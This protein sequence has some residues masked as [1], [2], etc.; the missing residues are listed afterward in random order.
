MAR[1]VYATTPSR[2]TPPGDCDPVTH[3]KLQ[4]EIESKCKSNGTQRCLGTDARATVLAKLDVNRA[5]ALARTKLMN[6]C[7][8]GGD[9]GHQDAARNAWKAVANCESLL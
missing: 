5:C 2:S 6:T 1:R 8:R 3:D 9:L 7:Y 4:N